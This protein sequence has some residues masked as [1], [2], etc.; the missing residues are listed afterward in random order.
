MITILLPFVMKICILEPKHFRFL[1][2][3][4]DVVGSIAVARDHTQESVIV[5][6][7]I[8]CTKHESPYHNG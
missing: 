5:L 3:F 4:V 7:T 8:P 6:V 1:S 2:V